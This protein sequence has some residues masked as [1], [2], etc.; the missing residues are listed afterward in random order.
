MD[1]TR[2]NKFCM[3]VF[4]V[5]N[6]KQSIGALSDKFNVVTIHVSWNYPQNSDY[7]TVQLLEPG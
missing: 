4:Y 3:K 7:I 6:Y 5:N 1:H 2:A